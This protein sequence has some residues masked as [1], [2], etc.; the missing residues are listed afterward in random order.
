MKNLLD[1]FK[2]KEVSLS[3]FLKTTRAI[4]YALLIFQMMSLR[5]ILL[6][7]LTLKLLMYLLY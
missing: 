5:I 4:A 1:F 3:G 2:G 7:Q 6:K